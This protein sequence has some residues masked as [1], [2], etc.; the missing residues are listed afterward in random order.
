MLINAGDAAEKLNLKKPRFYELVRRGAFPPG[1]IVRFGSRQIRVNGELLD[2]WVREGGECE[3][4]GNR[5]AVGDAGPSR[6]TP[7]KPLRQGTSM[8]VKSNEHE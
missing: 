7:P 5:I 3:R 2:Q 8:E 6:A 4:F 1:V